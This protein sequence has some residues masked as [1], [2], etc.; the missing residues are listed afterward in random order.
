MP[1]M[2]LSGSLWP[3]AWLPEAAVLQN[4]FR[5]KQGR[6]TACGIAAVRSAMHYSG[7]TKSLISVPSD[8]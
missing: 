2:S 7:M 3:R 4:A 1:R 5:R 8:P 6:K